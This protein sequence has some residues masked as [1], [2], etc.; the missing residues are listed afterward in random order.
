MGEIDRRRFVK[1]TGASA[2][3][4]IFGYGPF[5]EEIW[6][7]PAFS[8][9]PFRL[10]VASGDPEPDGV[11]LWTRLAPE[12]LADNGFGGMP[13][14]RAVEV[15]WEVARDESFRRTVRAGKTVARPGLEAWATACTSR[16]PGYCRTASTST[17]SGRAP[18]RTPS[19][20]PRRR[21]PPARASRR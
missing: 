1:L 12:P 3:A 18:L 20:G 21:R 8:G 19:A 13:K 16:S 5:T 4:M 9:Y 10:G 11:V 7:Q 17:G 14:D 2:A 15:R 6:A